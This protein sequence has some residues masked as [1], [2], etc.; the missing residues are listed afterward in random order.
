MRTRGREEVYYRDA[1]TPK[2][3]DTVDFIRSFF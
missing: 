2:I 3:L 1:P